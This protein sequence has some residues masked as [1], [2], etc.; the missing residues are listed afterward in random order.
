MSR[1]SPV[2][3]RVPLVWILVGLL[4][5]ATGLYLGFEFGLTFV[6]MIVGWFCCAFGISL[7]VFQLREKPR[8]TDRTRLSPNFISAGKT[9]V[10]PTTAAA[11]SDSAAEPPV[12][13]VPGETPNEA[14]A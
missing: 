3:E 6:Y 5:N 14:P 2:K 13:E 1:F 9:Q 10:F 4:F 8:T 7:L 11:N 12:S